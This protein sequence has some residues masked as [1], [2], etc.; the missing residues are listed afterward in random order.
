MPAPPRSWSPSSRPT[1]DQLERGL[2]QELLGERVADLHARAGKPRCDLFER[3]AGEHAD[4]RRCRRGPCAAPYRTMSEPTC[5]VSEVEVTSASAAARPTH[6]TL[7]VGFAECGSREADLAAHGRHADA[8][9]V[10]A[11]AGDHA[12]EQPAVPLVGERPEHQRVEQRDRARAHRDDVA[13]DAADPGGGALVRLDRAR[14][15]MRFHLEDDGH[16]VADVDGSGVLAGPDQHCRAFGRERPQVDL[17][18]LVASSAPTTS[19][20]TSRARC[21]SV[22]VRASRG[23]ARVRRRR[24]RAAVQGL[25]G[26]AHAAQHPRSALRRAARRTAAVRPSGQRRDR[27]HARGEASARRRCRPRCGRRRCCSSDRSGCAPRRPSPS[28]RR[29]GTRPGPRPSTRASSS[30]RRT[31]YCP[32]P[33]LIG[34]STTS[35][36]MSSLVTGDREVSTRRWTSRQTNR[37]DG[38]G[39]GRRGAGRTR[40]GSGSRCRCRAPARPDRRTP[41]P[42]PSRRDGPRSR[43]TA[44]S[45]RS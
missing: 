22:R 28:A 33:C 13:D 2:D 3:G 23:S 10:A 39:S 38:C 41:G 18:G 8:V 27:R 15:R 42:R 17:R 11:D 14:M 29:S 44:G 30:G 4:T 21:G 6:I 9:A 43:R 45:R 7:T 40:R 37:S 1:R 35:P 20:R 36:G 25:L 31:T 16:A 5:G 24:G 34:I 26:V 19:R 12:L 32:S